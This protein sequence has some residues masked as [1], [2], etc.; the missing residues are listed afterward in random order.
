MKF[1]KVKQAAALLL[2]AA[3]LSACSGNT[4][5][6]YYKEGLEYF[7]NGNYEK[8]E[9]S[10]AKALQL[11]G[12][13]A[14]Y[15]IDYA[16]SLIQLGKYDEAITYF[17]EAILKKDNTVVHKNNK[18]AY[19]GKGIAYLKAHNYEEAIKQFDKALAIDE[20]SD[21]NMD[22]LY[23]KGNAQ[24]KAGLYQDAVKTYTSI[25]NEKSTDAATYNYRAYAYRLMGEREKSLEDYNKA[26]KLDS[27]NYD[28]YFGKYF[29][30]TDA[31]EEDSAATVLSQAL[32]INGTTQEDKFN[33]AK[34][35][36]FQEEY[37]QAISELSEA[38]RNGFTEA[39][40]FLG[41]LYEKQE[42]YDN[43]IYNYSMYIK[44]DT[45]IESAAVYNQIGVCLIK[46]ER[47]DEAL[48]YVQ[49]GLEYNDISYN[50]SLLQNEIVCYEN[51]AEFDKAYG[52]MQDYLTKYPDDKKAVKENEF[53]KTRLSDA[54]SV[55]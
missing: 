46:Q 7:D 12:D 54:G 2:T 51:L 19:R 38:F 48:S 25:L 55:E 16:M 30:L 26:I 8:A 53:L 47:Y 10:F 36:Y 43:A 6:S 28:Y 20:S 34:I 42:D 49:A 13:R 52:S 45:S 5:G 31:G 27:K 32:K 24:E 15:Y 35:H 44:E 9:A 18:K 11:N 14:E 23:Y 3:M 41:N 22:I 39:Y 50:Q 4:A 21:L 17:D 37:D 1:K 40:Y 29:L 33:I